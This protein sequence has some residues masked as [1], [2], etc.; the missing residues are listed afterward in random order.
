[1]SSMEELRKKIESEFKARS[2]IN[3]GILVDSL[4]EIIEKQHE[5]DKQGM[6][7]KANDMI[8]EEKIVQH[9]AGD[10]KDWA[11]VNH[12]ASKIQGMKEV[13][14]AIKDL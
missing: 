12:Y 1:M 13:L 6:M 9:R 5:A 10:R 4:M 11:M 7:E 8:D 3:Y 14:E 2:L